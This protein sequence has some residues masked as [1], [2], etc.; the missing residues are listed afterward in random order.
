MS[1]EIEMKPLYTGTWSALQWGGCSAIKNLLQDA[2]LI[3]G[4][5]GEVLW[6]I[7][8]KT[9]PPSTPELKSDK[10]HGEFHVQETDRRYYYEIA[11]RTP[12]VPTQKRCIYGIVCEVPKPGGTSNLGSGGDLGDPGTWTSQESGGGNP[13]S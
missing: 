4:G 6:G 7:P 11:A 5:T 12:R 9:V 8:G 3:I 10:L 13:E 1:R 2:T